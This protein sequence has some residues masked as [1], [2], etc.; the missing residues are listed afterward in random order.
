MSVRPSYLPM[1]LL[2]VSLWLGP[3]PCLLGSL[4]VLSLSKSPLV[5]EKA[6]HLLVAEGCTSGCL[7]YDAGDDPSVMRCPSAKGAILDKRMHVE[8][9]ELSYWLLLLS[10]AP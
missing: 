10:L 6:L 8:V 9:L 3:L 1:Y 7:Q 2:V 4:L 5:P